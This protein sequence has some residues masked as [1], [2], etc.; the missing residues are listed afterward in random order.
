MNYSFISLAKGFSMHT[1][2][3]GIVQQVILL[4]RRYQKFITIVVT[5]ILICTG[6]C[7]YL[8]FSWAHKKQA[9]YQALAETLAEYD[10]AYTSPDLWSDVEFGGKTGYRQFSGSIVA[11][12]FIFLQAESLIQTGKLSEAFDVMK[13]GMENL[14]NKSP[15][16]SYFA[17]KM[18]RLKMSMDSQ[19][20]QQE[21]LRELQAI[22]Q[23][24]ISLARDKALYMLAEYYEDQGNVQESI[25]AWQR[26]ADIEQ[27]GLVSP[28]ILSAREKVTK[29]P[30][31]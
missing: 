30:R 5:G 3:T 20:L 22:A 23:D 14:S 13:Q 29:V 15:L 17:L 19:D 18:A 12:Y 16:Y 2:E 1:H 21:G 4:Y 24:T 25:D 31:D 28:W 8:Y 10:R 11:P 6:L 9:A 7:V 26:L 27:Q